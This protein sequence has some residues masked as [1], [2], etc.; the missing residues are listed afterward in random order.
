MLALMYFAEGKNDAVIEQLQQLGKLSTTPGA[1][2]RSEALLAN[3]RSP[4]LEAYRKALIESLENDG[5]DVHTWLALGGSYDE[6]EQEHAREAYL[7]A[8]ALDPDNE[9][10]LTGLRRA[11]ARLLDFESAISYAKQLLPRRPN[12]HAWRLILFDFYSVVQDHEAALALARGE[13]ARDDLDDA[14]RAAYRF[15]VVRALR[16]LGREEEV[17]QQLKGWA[18]ADPEDTRAAI[19][20]ADEYMNQDQPLKALPIFEAIHQSDVDNRS[21]LAQLLGALTAAGRHEKASQYALAL[22]HEDPEGDRALSVLITVL[23][24]ADRLDDALELINCKLLRTQNREHFQ[25]RA[26][27]LLRGAKRYDECIELTECLMDEVITLMRQIAGADRH[28]PAE[29]PDN[30]RLIRQP[31]EPFSPDAL[32]KRLEDLRRRLAFELMLAEKYREAEERLMTWSDAS[33]DRI[34]RFDYLRRLAR[35][36]LLQGR[37]EQAAETSERALGVEPDDIG[38]NNDVAYGWI[39]R[40][41]RLEEAERMIRFALSRNPT[42]GAYLDTYGWLLYKKGSF[43]ESKKWLLRAARAGDSGEAVILDH[44]GDTCWR[45]GESEEAIRYWTSAMA[46][47]AAREESEDDLSNDERRVR[48]TTPQKIEAVRAGQVPSVAP[49]AASVEEKGAQGGDGP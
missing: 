12:H 37:D 42:Q 43:A 39:D 4:D 26:G 44:L 30:E 10:A 6:F 34:R 40:G 16:N 20:L 7:E 23:A 48:D 45:L 35:C 38:F 27:V 18:D 32:H 9:D 24:D 5:P 8:L 49:V 46:A 3:L 13:E 22:V 25:H 19:W 15:G 31:N 21:S 36:Q 14:T 41:I 11:E 1:K 2:A 28:R 29:G 47:L 17:L 33:G